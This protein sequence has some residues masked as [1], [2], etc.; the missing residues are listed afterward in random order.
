MRRNDGRSR[1][2][3]QSFGNARG[4]NESTAASDDAQNLLVAPVPTDT[5]IGESNG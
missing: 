1:E 2:S 4:F 5:W 3:M